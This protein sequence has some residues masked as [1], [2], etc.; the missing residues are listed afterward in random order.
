MA[1]PMILKG[2]SF[3]SVKRHLQLG[4]VML[5]DL[6]RNRY[7]LCG[8]DWHAVLPKPSM[9]KLG[10]L[11]PAKRSLAEPVKNGPKRKIS[12]KTQ[13]LAK[14]DDPNLKQRV[15]T[16]ESRPIVVLQ[17]VREKGCRQI[18]FKARI[19]RFLRKSARA[20]PRPPALSSVVIFIALH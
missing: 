9:P 16:K 15:G 3:K 12:P 10:K 14:A 18:I 13:K 4:A 8:F 1:N 5:Y 20:A 17:A 6:C 19:M 7:E 2:F 11:S